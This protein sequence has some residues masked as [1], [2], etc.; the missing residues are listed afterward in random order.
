M[1]EGAGSSLA[2][3]VSATDTITSM[4]GKIFDLI[5]GNPLLCVFCAA[6]LL[7][8]GI[9]VFRKLKRAAK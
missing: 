2:T 9:S 1:E 6:G 3:I 7:G 4:V 5:V 8:V